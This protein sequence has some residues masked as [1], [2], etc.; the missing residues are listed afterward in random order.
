MDIKHRSYSPEGVLFQTV[1]LSKQSRQNKPMADFFFP[2]FRTDKNLCPVSALRDYEER[3]LSFHFNMGELMH[4]RLFLSLVGKHSPFT[5]STTARWLKTCLAN[6]DV[7]TAS[8]QAHSVR[9]ASTSKAAASGI[10]VVEILTA[11][12]WSSEGTFQRFYYRPQVP[13]RA[14]FG[15]AYLS[16]DQVSNKHV[17]I[18]TEPSE[19]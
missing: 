14:C 4:S 16:Q 8:F 18:E 1:H 2:A 6:A 15:K 13:S 19:M 12:D 17:D 5:S 9:G 3:T 10:T 7:D 11:A